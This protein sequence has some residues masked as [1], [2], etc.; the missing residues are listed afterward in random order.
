MFSYVD[1]RIKAEL[2]TKGQLFCIDEH[3]QRCSAADPNA[4]PYITLVGPIPL[5][6]RLTR[7]RHKT[8][9]WYAWVANSDL[10][11][12]E[13]AVSEV[14]EQ[15]AP[16]LF[17]L[18]TNYMAVNSVLVYGDLAR[19]SHPLVRVH[20]NCLTGDVFGSLRCDCGPQLHA[21]MTKICAE[22]V[23]IIVYMASHEGRGIG[24]WA[25]AITYLLQDAGEDTY[26]ANE[27]LGLPADSRDFGDAGR[28]LRHFLGPTPAVRLLGNN[29][30]KR[31]AL[32]AFGVQII[33][34]EPLVVGVS[35]YNAR[36][37]KSKQQHGHLIPDEAL[38]SDKLPE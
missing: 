19:A 11:R 34:Q 25:K 35:S 18:L 38:A 36:Y 3:G 30:I 4:K 28:V 37:L 29:P 32:D 26:Q 1:P 20:S 8:F 5:P 6:V 14:P 17:S 7:S 22:G 9:Q 23:G 13:R 31:A 12:I 10:G 21:A 15:G 33:E 27:R 2:L 24:L 16:R